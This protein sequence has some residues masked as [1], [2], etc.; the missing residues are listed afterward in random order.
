MRGIAGGGAADMGLAAGMEIGLVA[1]G[2]ADGAFENEHLA[3]S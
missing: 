1:F 2:A 3:Y